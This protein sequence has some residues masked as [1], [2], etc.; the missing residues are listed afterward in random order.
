MKKQEGLAG[1]RAL[2]RHA[3]FSLDLLL[4]MGTTLSRAAVFLMP[5]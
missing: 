3:R 2:K 1:M 4:E 5:D